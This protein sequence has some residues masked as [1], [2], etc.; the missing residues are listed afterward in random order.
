V[1]R[2]KKRWPRLLAVGGPAG[3][4]WTPA[5]RVVVPLRDNEIRDNKNGIWRTGS[6]RRKSLLGER[7]SISVRSQAGQPGLRL[8]ELGD[9]RGQVEIDLCLELS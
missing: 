6:V 8:I 7:L 2:G 3:R 5:D 9:K 1:R 4:A